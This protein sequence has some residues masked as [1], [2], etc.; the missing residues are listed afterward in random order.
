VANPDEK[1]CRQTA[2][3]I[4]RE[5]PGWIVLWGCYTRQFVAFPLFP[6]APGT[7]VAASY[8]E[9]LIARMEQIE[10]TLPR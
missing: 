9:A 2:Q 7:V 4:E 8:P 10:R 3:R 5:L 6:A 1:S